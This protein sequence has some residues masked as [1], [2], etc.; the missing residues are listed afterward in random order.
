M[1]MSNSDFEVLFDALDRTNEVQFR[2]L[3]TPLAQTNMVDLILSKEGYGDDFHFIKAK[4]SNKI[5]AKHSQGRA[6]NLSAGE[7]PSYSYDIIRENF[8][9]KNQEFFRAVYFDFA[10][11]WAIPIYQERP[12][13]SLKPVRDLSR[14][15][16]VKECEVLANRVEDQYVLH[17]DSKTQG[18][19]KTTFKGLKDQVEETCITA[20]SYDIETHV[21]LV[22]VHGGDGRWHDVPVEWKEYLPLQAENRFYISAEQ[23]AENKNVIARRNGLCIYN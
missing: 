23:Y 1:S 2:T 7:Y 17:P 16:S 14:L 12:V 19:L 18:I 22:P 8:L 9:G 20:L 4:R 3:F 5:I 15:Y 13:H 11:L 21:D 6:L 10:P